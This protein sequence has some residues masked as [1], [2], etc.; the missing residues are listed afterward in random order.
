MSNLEKALKGNSAVNMVDSLLNNFKKKNYILSYDKGYKTGYSNID[1]RQFYFQFRVIF[2]DYEEWLI[3]STTSIRSDRIDIQQWRSYHIKENNKRVTKT[4]IVYPDSISDEERTN[5]E[6]YNNKIANYELFSSIDFVISLSEL[7]LLIENKGLEEFSSGRRLSLKGNNYE[8]LIVKILNDQ[9]NLL[10]WNETFTNTKVGYQYPYF[11]KI[12]LTFG[13]KK[14]DK[15]NRINATNKVPKLPSGGSPKADINVDIVLENGLSIRRNISCK[16]T[17]KDWVS[18]HE[19]PA[20][21]FIY[22]LNIEDKELVNAIN[23]LQE[24]GGPTKISYE[25][26]ETLNKKLPNH[27]NNLV[28]WVYS[29]IG[30]EGQEETHWANYFINYNELTKK[31]EVYDLFNYKKILLENI[32]GQFNTPFKWTYPSGGKGKR[33]QLKG[34][35][36]F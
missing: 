33:I 32:E 36:K 5:A 26:L 18:V 17:S 10:M 2:K 16:N 29:G 24:K 14:T 21:S 1:N 27:N 28:D 13:I 7:Y 35:V 11:E 19:Y 15:I 8:E 31:F 9:E 30:G 20:E 25:T 12:L 6:R 22:V 3:Q 4:I 34:K 23:E